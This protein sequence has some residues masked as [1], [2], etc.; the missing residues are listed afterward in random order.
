MTTIRAGSGLGDSIYLRPIA[1]YYLQHRA[2]ATVLS[3]YPDVFADMP[4]LVIE[5][6]RRDRVDIVAHYT[7]G[8]TNLLTTQFEDMCAAAGIPAP[9][10][11]IRWPMRETCLTR[12]VRELAADRRIVLV[13]GGR[14][15]FNRRDGF[16]MDLLPD[17]SAF[18]AVTQ[19]LDRW[20]CF[21]IGIGDDKLVY[22]PDVDLDLNGRTS[23][24]DLFDL[25]RLAHGMVAQCSF[26][27]PLAEAL[28]R[29][30]LAIWASAA[31]QSKTAYVRSIT[32]KKILSKPTSS[33][34][35]DDAG[36]TEISG[37]VSEFCQF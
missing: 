8:K 31:A 32:P 4:G 2:P 1:E 29:P 22:S 3:N 7:A 19:L 18:D 26:A 16:G 6:F 14:E 12:E 25:A 17:W 5:P 23:V 28:D 36:W 9:A 35:M 27:V 11:E 37:A 15:P 33:Y 30:L 34:I 24:A 21:T 13:H 20:R 10:F